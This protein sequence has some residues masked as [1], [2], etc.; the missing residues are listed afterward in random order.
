MQAF[1][2]QLSLMPS[3]CKTALVTSCLL[4]TSLDTKNPP[5]LSDLTAKFPSLPFGSILQRRSFKLTSGLH[6]FP[7]LDPFQPADVMQWKLWGFQLA[8]TNLT[9]VLRQ[10]KKYLLSSSSLNTV[11]LLSI[12]NLE[13]YLASGLN[14]ILN[15]TFDISTRKESI[16][17]ILGQ[18][19]FLK[20]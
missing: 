14:L 9:V 17:V 13:T 20:N 16:C 8:F 11:C 18:Q 19:N 7:E 4:F 5:K 12:Q 3:A 15:L 2:R 1:R 10:E 6:R